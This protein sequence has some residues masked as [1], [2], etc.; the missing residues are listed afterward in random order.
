MAFR[1]PDKEND[2]A[3][4]VADNVADNTADIV[5][6]SYIKNYHEYSKTL[7]YKIYSVSYGTGK[8]AIETYCL[9]SR[10]IR[11]VCHS[12]FRE[13]TRIA[14]LCRCNIMAF[15]RSL[16]GE[17]GF[18]SVVKRTVR[19]KFAA[20]FREYRGYREKYGSVKGT[21]Q[22]IRFCAV[23]SARWLGA[24]KKLLNYA[25]PA[26]GIAV[27]S[28][29]VMIWSGIFSQNGGNCFALKVTFNGENLGTVK[30]Q[31]VFESAARTVEGDVR[32]ATGGAFQFDSEP[33]YNLVIAERSQLVSGAKLDS[34]IIKGASDSI[35][36]AYGL[37]V[38]GVLVG[39]NNSAGSIQTMLDAIL[40]PY[41]AVSDG[42]EIGFVQDVEIKKGIFPKNDLKTVDEMKSILTSGSGQAQEYVVEKGD[43]AIKIASKLKIPVTQLLYLNPQ[44]SSNKL[45]EGT[46]L[47]VEP[48]VQPY[49]SI[50]IVRKETSRQKIPFKTVTEPNPNAYVGQN[51]VKASGADGLADIT[52]AVTYVDGA[53]VDKEP[54]SQTTVKPAADKVVLVGSKPKPATVASGTFMRP[55][56]EGVGYVS[57]PFGGYTGHTGMD[58]ACSE[59]TPIMAADAGTVVFAGWGGGYGNCV[60]IDHGNGMLTVYG[61]SSKLLVA[62]GTKVYKGQVIAL[63]GE[64]GNATGN[65]VHFEIRKNGVAVN[66]APYIK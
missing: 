51:S 61:H 1:K 24:H 65:H 45:P 44:V 50:K 29:T 15:F 4:N 32:K 16:K 52:M 8:Y 28:A 25:A 14:G 30:S 35:R 62:Q 66:P 21:A 47:L 27:L 57:C 63:V 5:K 18:L 42:A 60:M 12:V 46:S 33:R 10:G 6:D 39:G 40:A 31:S 13:L 49:L 54:F 43:S 59:G 23:S 34:E 53:V 2:A 11:R 36:T 37:Y 55:I 64:T 58:I 17:D 20:F 48:P 19:A 38:D 22:W 3:D 26:M 56:E 9:I 7:K 41:R